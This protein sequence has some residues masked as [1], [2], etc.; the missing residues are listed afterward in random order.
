MRKLASMKEDI[1][2]NKRDFYYPTMLQQY[3]RK[4][5]RKY[6]KLTFQSCKEKTIQL[7]DHNTKRYT[8]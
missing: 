5:S 7:R 1:C 4:I 3:N 2:R 8:L 6:A